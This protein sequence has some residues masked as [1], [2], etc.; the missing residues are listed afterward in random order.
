MKDT[1]FEFDVLSPPEANSQASVDRQKRKG[2]VGFPQIERW[3]AMLS[4]ILLGE[5]GTTVWD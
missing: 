4:F 2:R 3:R 1:R 5:R